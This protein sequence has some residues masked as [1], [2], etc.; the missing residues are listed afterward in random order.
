MTTRQRG[1]AAEAA[2]LATCS[3]AELAVWL[4]WSQSGPCDLIVDSRTGALVRVQVK[5]GRVRD[6]C[7]VANCRTTDHGSGRRSC[8]G[9]VDLLAI[10]VP[11]LGDQLVVPI[12][13][14]RAF[15]MRLRL[16]PTRNNQRRGVHY[17]S[18]HRLQDWAS[19]FARADLAATTQ[20]PMSATAA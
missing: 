20:F 9:L 4:P 18:D 11:V 1:D 6:S 2:V 7:V 15:E 10:H 13:I 12:E 5:H 17:A 16:A 14:A 3:A 19:W 8:A